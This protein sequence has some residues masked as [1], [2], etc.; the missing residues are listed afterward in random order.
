M[1]YRILKDILVYG[2]G[3]HSKVVVDIIEKQGL[4]NIVGYI[5]TY[6]PEGTEVLGYQVVNEDSNKEEL[7]NQLIGVVV[8]IAD[9][10]LRYKVVRN[11]LS[12]YP[13]VTFITAIHPSAQIGKN[14]T[15][16][17]GTVIM[18]NTVVNSDTSVGNHCIINTKSSIDHDGRLGEFVTIA[19]GA[20]LAGNVTIGDHS[21]VSLGAK[22]IHKRTIGK[23][24]VIGAGA[25][26]LKDIES[27]VV[28]YGTPAQKVRR[29]TK[30]ERYL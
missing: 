20:T 6:K 12:N 14:V 26:V 28:A 25:T 10:W 22:V 15:I 3:R 27:Y 24:T 11:L 9:N 16:G 13:N 4:Y 21:V 19:P 18:A 1:R 2:S 8:A 29:R 7:Q 5:D 17:E 23:H 30:G